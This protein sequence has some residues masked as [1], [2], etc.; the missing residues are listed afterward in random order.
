MKTDKKEIKTQE[1]IGM[2][3]GIYDSVVIVPQSTKREQFFDDIVKALKEGKF[4]VLREG[5]SRNG[6]YILLRKLKEKANINAVFGITE[7][8]TD[9]K[10]I[11]QFA[12]FV[13]KE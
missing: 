4:F 2:K 1:N 5:Y 13:K 7:T 6:V 9:D 12:L 3:Q 8:K 11:K 10:T